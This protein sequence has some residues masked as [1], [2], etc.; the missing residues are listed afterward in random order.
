[1]HD[2]LPTVQRRIKE[3][4]EGNKHL[5]ALAQ[6]DSLAQVD[7]DRVIPMIPKQELINFL[8]EFKQKRVPLF[9][10]EEGTPYFPSSAERLAHLLRNFEE[11]VFSLPEE[12]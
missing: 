9:Y 2:Q 4:F 6:A 1:M 5:L 10:N 11:F 8:N 7:I 3:D 12:Y